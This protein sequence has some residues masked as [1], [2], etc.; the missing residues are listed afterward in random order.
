[1]C[2]CGATGAQ[3]DVK[4]KSSRA[5][6]FVNIGTS[7][8]FAVP[9]LPAFRCMCVCVRVALLQASLGRRETDFQIFHGQIIGKR[10][11]CW[12]VEFLQLT[13]SCRGLARQDLRANAGQ[14]IQLGGGRLYLT[15]FGI[16]ALGNQGVCRAIKFQLL[17]LSCRGP[18]MP[19]FWGKWGSKHPLGSWGIEFLD[20]QGQNIG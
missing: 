7:T 13:M 15:I 18:C 11:V 5:K 1:M 19:G 4:R 8:P 10:G 3:L 16:K 2:L 9:N 6:Y 14:N 20:F 12:A 17:A